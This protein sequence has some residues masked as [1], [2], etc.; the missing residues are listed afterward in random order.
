[1]STGARIAV[2]GFVFLGLFTGLTLKLWT[3]Q[4]TATE[5]YTDQAETNQVRVVETPAPRG[6]VRDSKGRLL[7]GT[8]PALAAV[9]DG[10]LVPPADD[11]GEPQF[12]QRLSALAAVPVDDVRRTLEDARRRSDRIT[13]VAELDDSQA[14]T[15]VEYGE[16]FPGVSVVPQ[17]VRVY[18]EGE[19]AADVL[20]YIG[21]PNEED[22]E[23][24]DI[25]PTDTVGRAGVE[26]QYDDDLRGTAGLIK[27]RVDATRNVL[28][29]I[30]E[31]P[32]AP[33][34]NLELTIDID[35]QRVLQDS[36][37]E[38]LH[39]ARDDYNP[40]CDPA[41]DP[42]CPVRAVGV[43]LDP[44]D[45]SVLAMASA[46][47]YDPNIFVDGVSVAE[48]DRLSELAV[49]NNFAIQGEYAPA[50]TFKTVAYMLA[51]EE[52]IF[53]LEADAQRHDAPYFCSGQ[54][55]FLF[56]DGSPQVLNDWQT[57]GHGLVDLHTGLQ[58]SCDL[59]FWQIA[60][61]IW[62]NRM[63]EDG[64]GVYAEDLLQKW[65][66]L[67][68]FDEKTGIDL[69]FERDGLIPDRQWF[70]RAQKETPG[71]VRDGPWTG[72]DVLNAVIGQGSVLT[73]PL[74]LAN[75]YA[76][77]VNGGTLWQPRV[78]SAVVGQSGDVV[79]E[80]AP[81]VL[82]EIDLSPATVAFLRQDLRSVV[83]GPAG[84][85]RSAFA[86]FGENLELVGGKTGTAEIIKGET[87]DEDVDT[88]VFVGVAPVMDPDYV[89]VVF[90]E[91]GG[92]GGQVAAPTGRR[93]LQY[94][95][96]GTTAMTPVVVGTE[97]SD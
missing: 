32:P 8:A 33:G 51:M 65:A 74:Q 21:D 70:E 83:S 24:P 92:S 31:Q 5:V 91:R 23:K 22:I 96:T 88:A 39:A 12:V 85:A 79:R 86:D 78:V 54:L 16:E 42:R 14:L 55:Q 76:A 50:S 4:V 89:V 37:V 75:A 43:V 46:P 72:G 71:L 7:A 3:V 58:T 6:E 30:N 87:A 18:P 35:V 53:A 45:G 38:G 40:D 63:R 61:N 62:T 93:I 64:T 95:L 56:T 1:M 82:R 80:N 90:V 44:N 81:K 49:F 77:M 27:Y 29:V 2:L 34:D 66:R 47:S 48:W 84:T 15:L 52:G 57:A 73:T 9:I 10:A 69:P 28:D 13:L 19:L 60:L 25:G 97:A 59:Y 68:G 11:P 67:F 26:R 17:P 20:G 36:L 41:Q 94:L